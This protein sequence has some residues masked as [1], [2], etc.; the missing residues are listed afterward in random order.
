MTTFS[1][2]QHISVKMKENEWDKME[3]HDFYQNGT[4]SLPLEKQEGVREQKKKITKNVDPSRLSQ[5]GN[6]E[7]DD[8]IVG[9]DL[10]LEIAPLS[11]PLPTVDAPLLLSLAS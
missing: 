9:I 8:W 7:D 6:P 11:S 4:R 3:K 5:I 2:T 10:S 1:S